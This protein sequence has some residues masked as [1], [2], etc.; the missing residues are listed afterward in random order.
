MIELPTRFRL[1][2]AGTDFLL[3]VMTDEFGVETV[4]QM[5]LLTGEPTLN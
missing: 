5:P 3:G 4:V 1:T 2:D